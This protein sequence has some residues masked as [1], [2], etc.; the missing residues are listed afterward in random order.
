MATE[1]ESVSPALASQ[2]GIYNFTASNIS[3]SAASCFNVLN[4]IDFAGILFSQ[5]TLSNMTLPDSA[6]LFTINSEA[7]CAF[8]DF[9]ATNIH[10]P[11]FVFSYNCPNLTFAS[12]FTYQE[13]NST[14]FYCS[15]N[16]TT[17]YFNSVLDSD[18]NNLVAQVNCTVVV[19]G[20]PLEVS[21]YDYFP[22]SPEDTNMT[23]IW[24]ELASCV[25]LV[26]LFIIIASV[27]LFPL[28]FK[29]KKYTQID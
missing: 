23:I 28:Y 17:L 19:Q 26:L 13:S 3:C 21:F 9:S 16:G 5:L 18:Q 24:V 14:F 7:P 25:A 10:G 27:L 20:V 11:I 15:G 22:A 29:S 1:T 6:D 8:E 4:Q 12:N 2:I